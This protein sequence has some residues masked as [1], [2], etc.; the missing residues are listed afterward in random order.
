MSNMARKFRLKSKLRFGKMRIRSRITGEEI[1]ISRPL[2]RRR[3]IRRNL[4][5]RGGKSLARL[6]KRMNN[7]FS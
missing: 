3:T 7:T 6:A 2:S 1:T 5:S 4:T